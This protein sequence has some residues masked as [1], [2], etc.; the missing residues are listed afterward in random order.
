MGVYISSR[1]HARRANVFVNGKPQCQKSSIGQLQ[2]MGRLVNVAL[3]IEIVIVSSRTLLPVKCLVRTRQSSRAPCAQLDSPFG[4]AP[5]AEVRG[6]LAAS[7]G[8]DSSYS[9]P[10][11][12][13]PLIRQI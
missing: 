5:P 7:S 8:M 1:V 4:P 11:G 10:N 2:E 9:D 13:P 12:S 6:G 3:G